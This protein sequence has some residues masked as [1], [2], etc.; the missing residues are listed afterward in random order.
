MDDILYFPLLKSVNIYV[1]MIEKT[2]KSFY[3]IDL[4]QTI[5][6]TVLLLVSLQDDCELSFLSRF[7]AVVHIGQYGTKGKVFLLLA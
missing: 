3:I 1:S 2:M 5:L 4:Y 6:F 7:G